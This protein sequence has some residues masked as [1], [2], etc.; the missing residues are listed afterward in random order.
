MASWKHA[1]KGLEPFPIQYFH[2]NKTWRNRILCEF[3]EVHFTCVLPMD[4]I[5]PSSFA[6]HGSLMAHDS[7]MMPKAHELDVL[8]RDVAVV[9]QLL[10][11]ISTALTK[12]KSQQDLGAV[13]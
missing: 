11:L 3:K 12:A 6:C 1:E 2:D 8:E 4:L 13:T 5:W 10:Q 9:Q 7:L